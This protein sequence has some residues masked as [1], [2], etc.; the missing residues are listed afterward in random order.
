MVNTYLA[1]FLKGL[2]MIYMMHTQKI[3]SQEVVAI[4]T[5]SGFTCTRLHNVGS[6]LIDT[7][8]YFLRKL[9][10]YRPLGRGDQCW[11]AI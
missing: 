8:K 6:N 7:P 9:R 3:Y 5:Q 2:E 10:G 1:A 11:L 4:I